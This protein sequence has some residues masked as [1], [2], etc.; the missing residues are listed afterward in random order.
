MGRLTAKPA[1]PKFLLVTFLVSLLTGVGPFNTATVHADDL[2]ER[3]LEISNSFAG[4]SEVNYF[5][6]FKVAT[7]GTVG[8]ISILLCEN[9][10]L[11]DQPC[12]APAGTNF[13]NTTLTQEGGLN[14]FS[15]YGGSTAN[16]LILTRPPAIANAG[17][18]AFYE[19]DKV[20]NPANSGPL[21]ARILTY[22]SSDATGTPIDSGGMALYIQDSLGI[23]VEV[24]PYLTFCL[25]E[26]ISGVDCSTATEPFS[27]MGS[28]SP[29]L[30]SAAQHQIVI[31]TNA[32]D[33]YS[34]WATGASMTSGGNVL[35]PMSGGTSTKG[36]SQFGINLRANSAP[37]IGQDSSG[38]GV[39]AVTAGYNQV[40]HFSF[41]SGDLLA[42]APAPDNYRKYT[43]SYIVNVPANQPG[44][45]Y[46]AALTYVCLANF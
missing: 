35:T 31:A 6:L 4:A 8:S 23:N 32:P 37:V 5:A 16:N 15:I 10:P 45:V 26:N 27:D 43:I 30:T 41:H 7:T 3:S 39:A 11:V 46:S 44:G 2:L 22:A 42:T 36:T 25:G 17:V 29:K 1:A 21:F 34:M 9:T 18:P 12:D 40:N 28:F 13:T 14:G 20:H 19:F 33:G 38:P 24:P